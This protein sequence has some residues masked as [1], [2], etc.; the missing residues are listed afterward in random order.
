MPGPRAVGLRRSWSGRGAPLGVREPPDDAGGEVGL[1]GAGEGCPRALEEKYCRHPTLVH[2][3]QIEVRIDLIGG[4]GEG[5]QY[6]VAQPLIADG[7]HGH[8]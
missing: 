2:G 1:F 4:G 8:G 7:G 5:K 6:P 3:D